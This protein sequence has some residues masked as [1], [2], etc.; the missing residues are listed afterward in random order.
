MKWPL[1]SVAPTIGR[2]VAVRK[3]IYWD[4]VDRQHF[5]E[6][7]AEMCG[8]TGSEVH[9]YCRMQNHFHLVIETPNGNLVGLTTGM[10]AQ[11]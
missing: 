7:R 10:E 9:A 8:K 4:G 1:A 2:E 5:P 6:T 3:D 11:R